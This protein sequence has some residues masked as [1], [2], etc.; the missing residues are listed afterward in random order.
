[1]KD[2]V[3]GPKDSHTTGELL[4]RIGGDDSRI[5]VFTLSEQGSDVQYARVLLPWVV[6]N[7]IGGV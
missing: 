2:I 4:H 1:M 7:G 3:S 6:G 5:G